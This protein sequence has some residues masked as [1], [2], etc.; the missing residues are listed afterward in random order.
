MGAVAEQPCR[1]DSSIFIAR[2]VRSGVNSKEQIA[3]FSSPIR[4]FLKFIKIHQPAG[5]ETDLSTHR[6]RNYIT[7]PWLTE[8]ES[9]TPKVNGDAIHGKCIESITVNLKGSRIG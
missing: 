3:L 2:R 5:T 7:S 9:D 4:K 6:I 1:A 8:T